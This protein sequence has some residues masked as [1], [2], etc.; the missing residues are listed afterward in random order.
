M[1]GL[2]NR[3]LDKPDAG[4]LLLRISFGVLMIFHGWHKVLAGVGA[5]SGML[6]S[7]G[8]PS[9]IAYGVYFGEVAAPILLILGILT[10]PA[11]LV[12]AGTMVVAQFLAAPA[13]FVSLAKTGAWGAEPTAVF[14]FAALAIALLGSGKYSVM[15]NPNLR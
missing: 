7:A 11:A 3:V 13:G 5:I 14:F 9:F 6:E 4:K 12:M 8:L 1:L 15:S 2:L 10:R